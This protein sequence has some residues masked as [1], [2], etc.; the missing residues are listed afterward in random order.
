MEPTQKVKTFLG[1]KM[2]KVL[3]APDSV[4]AIQVEPR[5][6][7]S[8]ENIEGFKILNRGPMLS[9]EQTGLLKSLIMDEKSYD[10]VNVKRHPMD[11]I[12]AYQFKK[13]TDTVNVLVSFAG[14]LWQFSGFDQKSIEDNDPVRAYLVGL[15]KELFPKDK[16][17]QA[18]EVKQ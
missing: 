3:Q 4:Q 9:A 16:E 15:A 6:G 12:I 1:E 13:G 7:V 5:A 17:I 18:L 10:F 14:N 8:L 2:L 11:P